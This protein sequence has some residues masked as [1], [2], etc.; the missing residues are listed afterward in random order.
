MQRY[1]TPAPGRTPSANVVDRP[2]YKLNFQLTEFRPDEYLL[3]IEKFIP[4]TGW[5]E[6]KFFLTQEE[7]TSIRQAING[8]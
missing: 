1:L 8:S 3:S 4:E 7:L 5:C 2:D 6:Q